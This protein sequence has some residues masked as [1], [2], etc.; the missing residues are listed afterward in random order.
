MNINGILDLSPSVVNAAKAVGIDVKDIFEQFILLERIKHVSLSLI[1]LLVIASFFAALKWN[2]NP[3][4]HD[5]DKLPDELIA[6]LALCA[7]IF[8]IMLINNI[9]HIVMPEPYAL[10]A[11][12]KAM[13]GS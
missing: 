4:R 5:E 6:I 11:L 9:V 8:V 3:N 1:S 13:H 2:R 10:E 12:I 7:A